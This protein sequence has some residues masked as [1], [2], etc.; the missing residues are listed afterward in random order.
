MTWRDQLERSKRVSIQ[1]RTLTQ[2]ISEIFQIIIFP[3]SQIISL[4]ITIGYSN[5]IC[6]NT[7]D[8]TFVL[9]EC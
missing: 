6:Q 1:L 8:G 2:K 9:R 4:Q 7:G 3:E 5:N